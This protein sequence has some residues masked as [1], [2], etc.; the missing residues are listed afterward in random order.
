MTDARITQGVRLTAGGGEPDAR[1]TQ[2]ARLTIGKVGVPARITQGVRLAV[3]QVHVD[4]RATQAVRLVIGDGVPCATQWQQLWIITRKDG[5]VFRYTSLDTDFTWGDDFYKSC[6]SLLPSAAE[7]AAAVGQVSNMELA[8]VITDD[9]ITEAE[10]YGGL[11]D[12]AFIQVWLVPYVGTEAPRR[13]AAGWAGNLSHGESGFNMEVVGP[14]ARLDQQ[15]MV[16]VYTPNCRWVFG[17]HRCGYDR[18]A[19]KLQ[20]TVLSS[21]NRGVFVGDATDPGGSFQ[22]AD[23]LIRWTSGPNLGRECEIKDVVFN[24]AGAEIELWDL[25]PFRPE[26]GDTF[27]LLPGCDL[28]PAACKMYGRYR[29]FGG[30]PDVPGQDAI[31]ARPDAKLS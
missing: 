7:E 31:E 28:S 19:V 21:L 22:W 4:V 9:G 16:Q 6:G 3:A 23:G 14:G 26:Y 18:E 29:F 1:I 11:F 8:G 5:V 15:A 12:D 30:Y 24:S 13:L 20:G 25:S 2:A 17:D 27:D 10:L